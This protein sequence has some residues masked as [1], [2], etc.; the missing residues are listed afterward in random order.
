MV[1]GA[2]SL[3]DPPVN[4]GDTIKLMSGDYG[5]IVIGSFAREVVNPDFV[6]V[7]AA[8]GQTPVF[9]TLYIRSTNKWVF[10]GVKVQSLSGTNNNRLVAR[11]HRGPGTPRSRPPTSSWR[12]S[13]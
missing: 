13:S 3:G 8:P 6:T 7:Q 5:D 11:D 9:S 4:P 1:I 10:K 12:T 2:D